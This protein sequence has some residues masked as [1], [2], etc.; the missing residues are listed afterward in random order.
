MSLLGADLTILIGPT[1]P[2]P[3]PPA[4]TQAI[5]DVE[6]THRDDG[7]SGFRMTL[8]LGRAGQLGAMDYPLMQSALLQPF[9]RVILMVRLNATVSVLMDGVITHLQVQ[10]SNEPGG[11]TVQVIG[12]D[13]SA[14]MDLEEK[15]HPLPP[16]SDTVAVTSVLAGYQRYGITPLVTPAP[17]NNQPPRQQPPFQDGTDLDYVTRLARRYRYVFCILPGPLPGTSRAYWGPR[18]LPGAPLPALSINL[19]PATNV[20]NVM[21]SYDALASQTVNGQVL[22]PTTDSLRSIAVNSLGELVLSDMPALKSQRKVR[23]V[24]FGPTSGLTYTQALERARARTDA[25]A[26]NTVVAEGQLDTLR[27]GGLLAVHRLIGMRGAG[28]SYDGMYYVK[29]ITH[30][31]RVGAYRQS[32]T[33]LRQGVGTSM[34]NVKV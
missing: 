30:S 28:A 3:A 11:S 4:L 6:V 14:L 27:Y 5:R 29:S 2:V 32:F 22:D 10:P 12:K 24:Q 31:L 25:A 33:M 26:N 7:L 18:I 20:D 21:F 1:I 13:I 17:D 16:V 19:G 8:W 15:K 23:S 34:T 9:N